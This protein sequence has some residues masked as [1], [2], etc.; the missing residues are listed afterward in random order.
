M[1]PPSLLIIAGPNGAGKSTYSSSGD[2]DLLNDLGISSFDY[3]LE[4]N[5]IYQRF[6]GYGMTS[7]VESG[8]GEHVKNMFMESY[9]GAL[10]SCSHFSFQTNF[11]KIY[12]EELR[13]EFDAKGYR[14]HLYFFYLRDVELCIARVAKRVSE[15]GHDVPSELIEK[16]FHKGLEMLDENFDRYHTCKIFDTSD[17]NE[18]IFQ[19]EDMEIKVVTAAFI[20]IVKKHKLSRLEKLIVESLNL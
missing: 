9:Q 8:I 16:R 18:L 12:S 1:P 14:T 7:Q 13:E 5:I 10:N 11:D 17:K 15:G 3:D 20:R 2:I 4:V 19:M 6:K